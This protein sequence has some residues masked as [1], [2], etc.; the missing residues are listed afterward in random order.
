MRPAL[1]QFDAQVR[2]CFSSFTGFHLDPS[3]WGHVSR[4][5]GH[6]GLGL[7]A[8]ATDA[9]AAYLASVG[10]CAAACP[11]LDAAYLSATLQSL[12][13]VV[14]TLAAFNEQ[15]AGGVPLTAGVVLGQPQKALAALLDPAA[16][17]AWLEEL[18]KSGC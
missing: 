17:C 9:A 7:R 14:Q 2:A 13:H 18:A 5:F 4:G 8:T 16:C 1:V 15:V 10:G 12:P 3:Q 6:A 11:A